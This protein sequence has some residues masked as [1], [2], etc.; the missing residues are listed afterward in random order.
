M[1][2]PSVTIL[3]KYLS[4]M[5]KIKAKYITAE[6]L[7]K[8]VGVY[9]EIINEN[10]SYFDPMLAMDPSADLLELVPEIKKYIIDIEEK[11]TPTVHKDSIKKKEISEYNSINDFV[12]QKMTYGG[13]L[14]KEA[15]LTDKDLKILKK[16]IQ[17]EQ[18]K[19]KKK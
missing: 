8:V 12:Y 17:D 2:A 10:L 1:K 4:A 19:R 7:S 14:N 3:K 13:M 11:K 16:L 5:Q 9:P 18:E 6:R 15:Y